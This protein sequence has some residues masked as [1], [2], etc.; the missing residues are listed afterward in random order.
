MKDVN[1]SEDTIQKTEILMNSARRLLIIPCIFFIGICG[2]KVS[3]Q[4]RDLIGLVS[5]DEIIAKE[6]IFDIYI[7]RYKPEAAAVEY[8]SSLQDSVTLYIFFGT[9]CRESKKYVPGLMK[10]LKLADSKFIRTIYIGTGRQKKVPDK[11][12]NQFNIKYIPTVVVLKGTEEVG[13]IEEK[14]LLPIE[15]DVVQILKGQRKKD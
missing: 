3:A 8:L 2:G 1:L 15:A 9:W 13:R 11:F 14:P 7:K 6:R 10:S 12:L 4:S 5:A